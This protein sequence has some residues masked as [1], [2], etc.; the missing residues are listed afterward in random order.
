MRLLLL[1][2]LRS[3][4]R[5]LGRSPLG[6][7]RPGRVAALSVLLWAVALQAR[8]H[9]G[10]G[11]DE[12]WR[13]GV[14]GDGVTVD[15][16]GIQAALDACHAAGGGQ[17]TFPAGRYLSGTVRLRSRVALVFEPGAM[18]VGTTNLEAYLHPTLPDFLPEA[19]WGKWHRALLLGE[20]AEDVSIGGSGVING[21]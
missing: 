16:V 10:S 5:V 11:P 21:N 14:K 15:T 6:L 2:A 13:F 19:K 17:V 20:N 3:V 9:P 4:R 7:Q 18:L 1:S 12:L 8:S